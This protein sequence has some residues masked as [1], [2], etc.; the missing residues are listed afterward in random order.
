MDEIKD[1]G[2][3]R[4]Y[5]SLLDSDLWLK[6]PFTRGQAWVDLI[7]LAN[8]ADTERIYKGQPQ[9]VRRGQLAVSEIWLAKRWQWSRG[10]VRRYID[11]LETFKMVSVKRTQ[12]GT[13]LTIENYEKYQSQRPGRGTANSTTGGTTDGTAGGTQKKKL[14]IKEGEERARETREPQPAAPSGGSPW[15]VY[16]D[17]EDL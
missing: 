10:R 5:R 13:T 17:E 1:Y 9:I 6:E 16:E 4:L 14:R 8:Y 7:G 15:V 3:I 11:L 12:N 2:W